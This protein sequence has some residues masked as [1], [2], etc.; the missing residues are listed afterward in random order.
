MAA[1]RKR[2]ANRN[3]EWKVFLFVLALRL[4]LGM[5]MAGLG[6]LLLLLLLTFL[7]LFLVARATQWAG[8]WLTRL[9]GL[10]TCRPALDLASRLR[11]S[12]RAVLAIPPVPLFD[13]RF[14]R[15]PP[16]SL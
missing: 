3:F 14:Q 5:V 2:M 1:K 8:K 12:A 6:R 16:L 11:H 13:P 10:A 4:S 7:L 15:P 9:A